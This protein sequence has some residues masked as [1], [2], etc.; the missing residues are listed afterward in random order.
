MLYTPRPDMQEICGKCV[1]RRV[2]GG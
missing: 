2:C 1:K